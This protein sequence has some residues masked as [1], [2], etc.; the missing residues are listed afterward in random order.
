M[1][2]TQES[3]GLRA[4]IAS[5]LVAA[6][7]AFQANHPSFAR[8]GSALSVAVDPTTV[9]KKEYQ[10][11]CGVSFDEG[12]LEQRLKSTNFLYPKHVEVIEDIAP[13]AGTMVDEIVSRNPFDARYGAIITMLVLCPTPLWPLLRFLSDSS[14]S[15]CLALGNRYERLA[16]ARFPSR[17]FQR[18]MGRRGQGSPEDGGRRPG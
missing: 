17:P 16:T 7:Y 4:A 8:V 6:G 18:R 2:S 1:I 10:D 9:T 5:C 14:L 13:I 11:I 12:S 15:F 3:F